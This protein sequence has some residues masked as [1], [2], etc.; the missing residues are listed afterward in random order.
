MTMLDDTTALLAELVAFPTVSSD[1]NLAMIAHLAGRLESSGARVDIHLDPDGH[2]A[3][4]FATIGPDADGGIVLSGHTDVVPTTDQDWASDPF[5]LLEKDGRLFGRGACDMKGFIAAAVIMAPRFAERVRDRPLHFA[6]THDE[7]VGCIGARALAATLLEKGLRP[8]V[9]V[10]GE[11]TSMRI[12]EGHKGCYEYTT[13]FTGLEGHGS[14]PDRGVNAVEYAVR[15]VARLLELKEALKAR[16][17]AQSRFEP[18]W[19][20][21]NTGALAGGHAH[22]VIPG[23]ARVDWEM[24]PM[25]AGDADFVKDDLARYCAD[26]LLP[27]MRAVAP[28]ADIVT[29]T[30][31]EVD[32]LLP[33]DENEAKAIVMEL[34]GATGAELVPFGTEAGIF[35]GLGMSAVICG[36]GSI[37]QAHKP[38]EFVSLAQLSDC[39]GML[40][41]LAGKL[42]LGHRA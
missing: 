9:A 31:G 23:K 22:N 25:Q 39:L 33:A 41:R 12:V 38:D 16:G 10:I 29:E 15:Y 5:Q 27:A 17:P 30:I 7:E 8:S 6:F 42:A 28:G 18:P 21:I 19:T 13:H 37:E 40:E 4:L 36:P 26:T 11:P 3:N 20:T 35:Q 1:S 34:T 14:A 24:R 2:K 32:G